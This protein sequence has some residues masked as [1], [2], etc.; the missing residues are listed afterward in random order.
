MNQKV[1]RRDVLA[2]E[3]HAACVRSDSRQSVIRIPTCSSNNGDLGC[4]IYLTHVTNL[5]A[6]V[7]IIFLINTLIRLVVI[8]QA[9]T[10]LSQTYIAVDPKIIVAKS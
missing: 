3:P 10:E 1:Y 6:F 9:R 5:H 8:V 7:H 4:S 2:S